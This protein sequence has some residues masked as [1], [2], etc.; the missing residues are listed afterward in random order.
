MSVEANPPLVVALTGASGAP[1]AVRLLGVLLASGRTV[2]LLVSPAAAQVLHDEL[3]IRI[4][5]EHFDAGPLM[6]AIERSIATCAGRSLTPASHWP[7]RYRHHMD[8]HAGIASG[9]F[10]TDGMVICP[11]SM[12][13]LG[14]IATGLSTNLIQRAADVHLKERRKL[15]LGPRE[16]PLNL[17]QLENMTRCVRAGAVLLPAMPG[18]YHRPQSLDDMIDFIVGR[19][20]DQL[21]VPHQLLRRWGTDTAGSRESP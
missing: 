21:N 19:I 17:M 14:A 1:Y 15:I 2:E 7:L 5:T 20:C 16:T 18:W 8:W 13:T 10:L 6:P 12:S 4:D 11:C 9:S 3:D